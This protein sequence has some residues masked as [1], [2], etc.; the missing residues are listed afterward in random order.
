MK[1]EISIAWANKIVDC[2]PEGRKKCEGR[3]CCFNMHGRYYPNELK[4]LPARLRDRLVFK[5]GQFYCKDNNGICDFIDDCMEHPEY[6]P[7]QCKIYPFTF[8]KKGRL[9]LT[10]GAVLQCLN[11]NKGN[12]TIFEN[13]KTDLI[14]V[15][16]EDW[17]N[18][19][20]KE[21]MEAKE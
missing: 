21:I 18:E 16:G 1:P 15:F 10:D 6:R 19:K 13:L 4:R 5:E 12:K 20:L 14:D 3:C 11:F 8:N 9:V 17:Y 7:V 2:T